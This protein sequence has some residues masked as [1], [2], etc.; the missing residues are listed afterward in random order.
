M[1]GVLGI[2]LTLDGND[3][4][5]GLTL[6]RTV[7][8]VPFGSR[9]RIIDFMLSSMIGGGIE[10][11][12]IVLRDRYQSLMDHLGTGKDWDLSRRRGGLYLLPPH[13]YRQDLSMPDNGGALRGKIEILAGI[14]H[15]L[16][17]MKHHEYVVLSDGDLVINLPIDDMLDRHVQSGSDITILCAADESAGSGIALCLSPDGG[18]IVSIE[19]TPPL[20]AGGYRALGVYIMKRSLLIETITEAI[21]GGRHDF[22]LDIIMRHFGFLKMS[23]A[24]FEG[25]FAKI[26]S[27][28]CYFTSSMRL[29]DPRVRNE[30][31][32]KDRPVYTKVHDRAP[33]YYGDR[34]LCRGSLVADGCVIE[35][36]VENSV[37]FRGV[38]IAP[39]AVVTNSILMQGTVVHRSS[40]LDF[41]VADKNV[42][43][44][45]RRVISGRAESPVFVA[46]NNIV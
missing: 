13:S 8:S 23:A 33:V 18:R 37:L 26:Q 3:D 21:S 6:H 25:F 32:S 22:E 15:F 43:V 29:L 40:R 30:L 20:P 45:D 11:V 38:Q 5:R 35:G 41:V 16:T 9:Y 27:P 12:A 1:K 4:L 39:D 36:T 2:I 44:R 24:V 46:K 42:N 34:A 19:E 10:D 28:A 17:H 31:F 7:P 14:L